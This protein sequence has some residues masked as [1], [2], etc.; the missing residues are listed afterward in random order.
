MGE[1]LQATLNGAEKKIITPEKRK[2]NFGE[3]A[4]TGRITNTI[5]VPRNHPVFLCVHYPA[6]DDI[7]KSTIFHQI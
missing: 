4:N 7:F 6:V 3:E 1:A 2:V 5:V